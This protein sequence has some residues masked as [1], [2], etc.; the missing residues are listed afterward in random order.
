MRNRFIIT[1]QEL[2]NRIRSRF[3]WIMLVLGPL[4]V[5]SSIYILFK[6]GDEGKQK[7]NVLVSDEK[8]NLNNH[9]LSKDREN[10]HYKCTMRYYSNIFFWSFFYIIIKIFGPCI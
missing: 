1:K 9:F 7:I 6:L 4:I 10:I 5:L 3:F 2:K 8:A